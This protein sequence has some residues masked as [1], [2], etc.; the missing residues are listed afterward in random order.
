MEA[1]EIIELLRGGEAFAAAPQ[2]ALERV[3]AVAEERELFAGQELIAQGASGESLWILLEGDLEVLV[4]GQVANRIDQRG[5][6]LG[7]I[8]AVSQTPATA[9]VI[10]LTAGR[11]LRI[12]HDK[13]HEAML[14]HPELA[15]SMLRSMAKYLGRL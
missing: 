8:S 14:A 4:S 15:A 2:A 1:N 12:P 11:A 9:T 7:Q 6:V 13:L 5:E 10:A 3:A